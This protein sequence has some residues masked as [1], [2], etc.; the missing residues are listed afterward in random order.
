M[1]NCNPLLIKKN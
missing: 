1:R